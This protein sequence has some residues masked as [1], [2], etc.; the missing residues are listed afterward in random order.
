VQ[1]F[2]A[3]A[4]EPDLISVP[5]VRFGLSHAI[6]CRL[7]DSAAVEAIAQSAGSPTLTSHAHWAGIPAGWAVLSNY[8]PQRAVETVTDADFRPLDPGM[9]IEVALAGGLAIRSRVYA[10]GHPPRILIA[11]IPE[12]LAVSISGRPA[13]PN[14]DGAWEAPGWDAPGQHTIDVVP[15]P[16]LTYQIAGDP[17]KAGGWELWNAHENRFASAAPW[18][19]AQI[20]GAR[21]AGPERQAVVAV[22]FLPIL[23]AVGAG[24]GVTEFQHRA[25]VGMAVALCPAPPAFLIASSGPRRAN[26]TV[27]WL[28]QGC[29][30]AAHAAQRNKDLVWAN[31][32]HSAAARRWPL[33]DADAAGWECWRKAVLRARRLRRKQR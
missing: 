16:S 24:E 32:V 9:G 33:V 14:S 1:I 26:G 28:G 13:S 21:V 10:E 19:R 30:A 31:A 17:A 8:V 29:G 6:V 11:P 12:G 15:G 18:A 7:E 27:Q 5:A 25:D 22:E 23:L 20:C 3:N 4:N 2:A